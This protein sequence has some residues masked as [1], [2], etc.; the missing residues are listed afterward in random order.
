MLEAKN[1]EGNTELRGKPCKTE[2]GGEEQKE[3]HMEHL[4]FS[5]PSRSE[6]SVS[7]NDVI[8]QSHTLDPHTQLQL[9]IHIIAIIQATGQ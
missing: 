1:T 8:I 2:K 6:E 7:Y 4:H 5:L 3:Y 9:R